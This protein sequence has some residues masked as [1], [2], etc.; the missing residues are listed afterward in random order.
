[1]SRVMCHMSRVTCHIFFI[2][3]FFG[4]SGEAYW[5]RVCYKRG[6]PCLVSYFLHVWVN[7][8]KIFTCMQ[9]VP[10]LHKNYSSGAIIWG[11]VHPIKEN[12]LLLNNIGMYNYT[13]VGYWGQGAIKR[14]TLRCNSAHVKSAIFLFSSVPCR[15]ISTV[16]EGASIGFVHLLFL[17]ESLWKTSLPNLL[18]LIPQSLELS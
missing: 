8:L 4:Q 16:G 15:I 9:E 6:L 14:S 17:I 11:S 2:F 10:N 18:L 7:R 12:I 3:F 13:A 1:M 5:W